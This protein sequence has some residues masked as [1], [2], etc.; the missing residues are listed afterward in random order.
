MER[1]G[2]GGF[3]PSRVPPP[4]RYPLWCVPPIPSTRCRS[5]IRW[6]S[7][8]GKECL[9]A[10][11]GIWE[12]RGVVGFT[13]FTSPRTLRIT[14]QELHCIH[15]GA[16]KHLKARACYALQL[17]CRESS[18][19]TPGSLGKT[20]HPSSERFVGSA[21]KK[22]RLHFESPPFGVRTP[23]SKL[24]VNQARDSSAPS[25]GRS[26]PPQSD[27]RP[28]S[29]ASAGPS[30]QQSKEQAVLEQMPEVSEF[31][32]TALR[33]GRGLSLARSPVP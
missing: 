2:G 1:S 20:K 3:A 15:A 5:F 33:R 27:Q 29:Q 24:D 25:A 7:G 13:H 30:S 31:L 8:P 17:K 6:C 18:G 19:A 4:P 28:D 32:P 21:E 10:D 16:C 9:D 12:W 11:I 26:P 14:L 23:F 22:L